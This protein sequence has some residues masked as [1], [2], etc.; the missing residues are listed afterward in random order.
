MYMLFELATFGTPKWRLRTLPC[1]LG[2]RPKCAT[3]YLFY[4]L[5]LLRLGWLYRFVGRGLPL[6]LP[7]AWFLRGT[8]ESWYR[9]ATTDGNLVIHMLIFALLVL[10]A[11]TG[12]A[13]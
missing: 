13:K 2:L 11:K 8:T 6:G 5:L 4:G 3:K 9:G 7:L 10:L 1:A 12:G